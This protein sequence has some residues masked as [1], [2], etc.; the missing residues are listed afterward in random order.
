MFFRKPNIR[1]SYE[2]DYSEIIPI[3]HFDIDPEVESE[4]LLSFKYAA[5]EIERRNVCGDVAEAGVMCG[6]FAKYVNMAFPNRELHL[7]DTFT[8]FDENELMIDK[9]YYLTNKYN[10]NM[11]DNADIDKVKSILPNAHY[12]VGLFNETK[13]EVSM[14]TFCFVSLD[15]DLFI[16]TYQ[17]LEFFYPRL[18]KNGYIFL[19]DYNHPDDFYGVKSALYKFESEYGNMHITPL[20]DFSGTIVIT[21]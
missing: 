20:P 3:R 19:H 1:S 10:Y 2:I 13:N 14:K 15:M 12:H 9:S 17:G 7:F 11:F 16:P 4:R 8:G 5:T 18:N 6:Y 21:R